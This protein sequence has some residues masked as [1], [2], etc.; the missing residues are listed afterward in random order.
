MS[1]WYFLSKV[2]RLI[3]GLINVSQLCAWLEISFIQRCM[4]LCHEPSLMTRVHIALIV[5]D[6][7]ERVVMVTVAMLALT[8]AVGRHDNDEEYQ[9]GPEIRRRYQRAEERTFLHTLDLL[10]DTK[11]ESARCKS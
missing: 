6:H 3:E 10:R 7:S 1:T 8:V 2:G 4:R 5:V 9:V 11:S